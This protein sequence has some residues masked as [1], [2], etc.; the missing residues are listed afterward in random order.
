MKEQ[1]INANAEGIADQETEKAD[2]TIGE[3]IEKNVYEI[4]RAYMRLKASDNVET[5]MKAKKWALGNS[6]I[7]EYIASET[8]RRAEAAIKHFEESC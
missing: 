4:T 3:R 7:M 6:E 5:S 1:I 8:V 2:E